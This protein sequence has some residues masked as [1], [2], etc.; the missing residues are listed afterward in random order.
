MASTKEIQTRIKSVN[1]I[2]KI[3]NAMYLISSSKY[4]KARQQLQE[5]GPYF[6]KLMT[7]MNYSLSHSMYFNHKFFDQRSGIP[8][9]KKKRGYLIVTAD[10]GMCGSYSHNIIKL[11]EEELEKPEHNENFLY[12]VGQVGRQYF[13][14]KGIDIDDTFLYAAQ[15][16]NLYRAREIGETLIDLFL[17]KQLDEVYIVYT[18]MKNAA[19]TVPS[20]VKVLPLEFKSFSAKNAKGEQISL[21]GVKYT[22]DTETVMD[23]LVPN[24]VKG[25][26][27]GALV[28]AYSSVNYSRMTAMSAASDSA[29]DMIKRYKLLYNRA[30]QA[31]ITQELTE[32]IS[33][34][35]SVGN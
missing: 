6:S 4:R 17:S 11:A 23:Y 35:G 22:P 29:R 33:G 12:V 13:T 28:E 1:D 8:E 15:D 10:R 18:R 25:M 5:T 7:A 14:G 9:D 27:Y 16:P 20:T 3:T 32:I 34:A 24:Y 31:S 19:L 30:R 26:V 2:L 21:G